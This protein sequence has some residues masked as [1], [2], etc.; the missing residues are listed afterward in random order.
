MARCA[1]GVAEESGRLLAIATAAVLNLVGPIFLIGR[2]E[3]PSLSFMR[4][5]RFGALCFILEFFKHV[6][7]GRSNSLVLEMFVFVYGFGFRPGR[8]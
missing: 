8:I 7:Y 5:V 2:G 1:C 3:L 4:C 6:F